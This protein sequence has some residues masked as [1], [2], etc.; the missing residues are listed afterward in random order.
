MMRTFRFGVS[1]AA[2]ALAVPSTH[3]IAPDAS[4]AVPATESIPRIHCR[5]VVIV[6]LLLAASSLKLLVESARFKKTPK[7]PPTHHPVL[8]LAPFPSPAPTGV[9]LS[10]ILRSTS[11]EGSLL[12]S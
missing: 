11:D 10:V 8:C 1:A 12:V 2:R 5:F 3:N 9:P 6:P 4:A 7:F